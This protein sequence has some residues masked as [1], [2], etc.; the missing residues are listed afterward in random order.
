MRI[1]P[2]DPI[3]IAGFL[4][5]FDVLGTFV[6]ALSGAVAGTGTTHAVAEPSDGD[7]RR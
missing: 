4:D 6:F 5:A 1:I 7:A 2:A 3:I